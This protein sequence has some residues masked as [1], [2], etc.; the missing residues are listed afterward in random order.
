LDPVENLLERCHPSCRSC[1]RECLLLQELDVN[2]LAL[3]ELW[4]SGADPYIPFSC[5]ACDL[6]AAICTRR[7]N[8]SAVFRVWRQELATRG[9]N[10]PAIRSPRQTDRP[11]NIYAVY[12]QRFHASETLPAQREARIVFFPGCALITFTPELSLAAFEYLTRRFPGIGW[13]SGCCFD[14]LDKLGLTERFETATQK[15]RDALLD[16]GVEQIVTAC[17]TCHYRLLRIV[18]EVSIVSIY[19][20]LADEHRYAVRPAVQ[21]ALHDACPDRFNQAL[22]KA[23]RTLIGSQL[24]VMKHAD[25]RTLCC[26]AGGDVVFFN[27][28]LAQTM[29]ERRRAEA[30]A[31][32]AD[33]LVTYCTTCAIQLASKA[34]PLR[35]THVLDLVFGSEHDYHLVSERLKQTTNGL[36]GAAETR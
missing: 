1:V 20:L 26:G 13:L 14:P 8:P 36:R 29:S 18:P 9:K 32:G 33:V 6:C 10:S 16:R 34:G 11:D 5:T 3:V 4:R 25:K 28:E 35:V 15:F 31:S 19:Q 27:P 2:G 30:E 22:G 17:P 7:L 21:L 23:V 12:R 24:A